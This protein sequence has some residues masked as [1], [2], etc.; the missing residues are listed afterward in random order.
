MAAAATDLLKLDRQVCFPLY[1]VSR[2][3][4]RLYQP[5]LEPLG[6]TYPQYLVLMVLWE[7]AP[8]S[9]SHIGERTMLGSNTLTPLLKRMQGQKLIRRTRSA[10]DERVVDIS[11]TA[12]GTALRERCACIPR[13]FFAAVGYPLKDAL[14]LKD[15]LDRLLTHLSEHAAVQDAAS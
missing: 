12:A 11:L 9:V 3:L 10:D 15:R 5:L 8:C 7:D 13:E 14:E 2:L 1:A 4:T 6:L